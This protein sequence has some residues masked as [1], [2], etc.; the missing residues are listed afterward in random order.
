MKNI[1]YKIFIVL[2]VIIL[3]T[4][5]C[6]KDFPNTN[7]ASSGEVL[8]TR[9]GMFRYSLSLI[10]F[11]STSTLGSLVVSTG[12][13]SREIKG[14]STLLNV[15]DIEAGGIALPQDNGTVNG[16]F[17]NA[18]RTMAAS[19][20]IIANAPTIL[21]TDAATLSGI[22]ANAKLFKAMAIGALA[23]AYE[24]CP[25]SSNRD[26]KATYSTRIT[27]LQS[28]VALLDEAAATLSTT[29]SSAEF[30]TRILGGTNFDLVNTVNAFKARY[31]LM[32]GNYA[33]AK[34]AADLVNLSSKSFFVYSAASQNPGFNNIAVPSSAYRPRDNFGLPASLVEA[35]D[36][37]RNFYTTIPTLTSGSDILRT[38]TGFFI[39]QTNNIPVY[40]PDEMR[41]IKAECILRNNTLGTIA[42]ALN[43]I[44][45]VRTQT[46]GD[47]LGV[48]PALPAYSGT[49]DV[50]SLLIETY[51]QRC[52]ELYLQGVKL[53]DSRRFGRPSATSVPTATDERTRN[54]YP[55]PINERNLNPNTPADPVI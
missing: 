9:E 6:K 23:T 28:A 4:T 43:E 29:P 2:T 41:L 22:M 39:S 48:H 21:S 31:N 34:A 52:S 10:Q 50:P 27:A 47:A 45:G 18:M 15:I 32:A 20:E 12:C 46:T 36:A 42:Q 30:N 40:I 37:R 38:M 5:S 19:E 1:I 16:L 33:A 54:F 55:Y 8:T 14:I 44:N 13:T 26:G 25:T 7:T 51:R 53:E 24:N 49:V 35:A 17:N 3:F 11:Y